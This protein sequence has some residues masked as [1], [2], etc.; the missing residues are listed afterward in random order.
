MFPPPVDLEHG[1]AKPKLLS[2]DPG[3]LEGAAR[4]GLLVKYTSTMSQRGTEMLDDYAKASQ[5][6]RGRQLSHC[7]F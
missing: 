1:P 6:Y 5:A 3:L 2:G 7:F 4:C